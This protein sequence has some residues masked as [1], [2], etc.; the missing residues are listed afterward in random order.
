MISQ[1]ATLHQRAPG[2]TEAKERDQ[3]AWRAPLLA[4]TDEEKS[5]LLHSGGAGCFARPSEY[6]KVLA[7]LLNNGVSPIT[8][9]KV[10]E[11]STVEEMFKNQIPHMPDFARG[12][13]NVSRPEYAN[14]SPE[15]RPH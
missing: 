1:L 2:S 9:K 3:H 11:P 14:Q 15:V 5:K 4:K 13:I 6:V 8:K 12:G 7:M 10:L